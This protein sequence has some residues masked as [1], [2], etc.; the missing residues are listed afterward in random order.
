[1]IIA[2]N[3]STVKDPSHLQRL[4]AEHGVGKQ[5]KVTV[6]RDGKTVEL[7]MTLSSAEAMP[8]QQREPG[9]KGEQGGQ[10]D[11]LGLVVD[12]AEQGGVVV[13]DVGRGSAAAEAGIRRGDVI[14]SVNRKKVSNSAEYQRTVQQAARGGSLTV[15]VRRGDASIY[16]A[17]RIK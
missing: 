12:D 13:V 8:R 11:L 3:G 2:F 15:L 5:A 10:G 17:L 16:F 9:G 7:G 1:M 14:V 6:F 4:V